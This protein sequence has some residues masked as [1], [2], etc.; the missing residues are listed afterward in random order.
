MRI[1]I[2][3]SCLTNHFG[4]QAKHRVED[5]ADI[6]AYIKSPEIKEK[7]Y[8]LK[9][10]WECSDN[11]REFTGGRNFLCDIFLSDC[12]NSGN[13]VWEKVEE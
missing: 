7:G 11:C 5:I 13:R 1:Y 10:A 4:T 6:L 9:S 8:F 12:R 3:K 2:I